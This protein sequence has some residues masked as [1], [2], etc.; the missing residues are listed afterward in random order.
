MT[1]L[2]TIKVRRPRRPVLPILPAP[3]RPRFDNGNEPEMFEGSVQGKKA[4]MAEERF[5][6]EVQ[7]SKVIDSW[8][9][10]YTVGAPRGMPGWKELDGL[11]FSRGMGYAIEI[12]S[13]FT[14]RQK[15]EADRLHDAIILKA[16]SRQGMNIFPQVFHIDGELDLTSKE[17]SK[18]TVERL[19]GR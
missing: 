9:F 10:R 14:H 3:Q 17:T 4:S 13:T 16:L 19:F 1:K 11:I 18:R 12:D 15:G 8:E 7:K 6:K 5:F 2:P